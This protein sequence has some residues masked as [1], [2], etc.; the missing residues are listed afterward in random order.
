MASSTTPQA[1]GAALPIEDP[2]NLERALEEVMDDDDDDGDD[3]FHT[4]VPDTRPVDASH[5]QPPRRTDE[6]VRP[7]PPDGQYVTMMMQ[8]QGRNTDV[9]NRCSE[10]QR[11]RPITFTS[12]PS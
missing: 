6:V 4:N 1:P 12:N 8:Q 3:S 9:P 10:M 2:L 11:K 5:A 7:P